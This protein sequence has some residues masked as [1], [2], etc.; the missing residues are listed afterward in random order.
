MNM[1][2]YAMPSFYILVIINFHS[3]FLLLMCVNLRIIYHS[4]LYIWDSIFL[5][6]HLV[7]GFWTLNLSHM[8]CSFI[9]AVRYWINY[10]LSNMMIVIGLYFRVWPHL[11]VF[12]FLLLTEIR[13]MP[14]C[15]GGLSWRNLSIEVISQ[16]NFEL[17]KVSTV[18]RNDWVVL[19]TISSRKIILFDC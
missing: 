15:I 9:T 1:N 8:R 2:I 6:N 10:G 11:W 14:T 19:V 5:L 17:I 12:V 18:T 13:E 16:K 3:F 7:V 4:R